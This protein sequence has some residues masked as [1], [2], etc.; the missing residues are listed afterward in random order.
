M[1]FGTKSD[2][3]GGCVDFDAVC[4]EVIVPAVTA[5]G[6]EP[7]RADEEMSGGI[8]HKP[9]FER[10]ILCDYAVADLTTANANVFCELG[11]RHALR[12]FATVL[13]FAEGG[14]LAFDVGAAAS[15]PV[16]PRSFGTARGRRFGATGLDGAA[17]R[18][19][20]TLDRQS[21][22]PARRGAADAGDR[23]REDRR[24]P[25]PRPLLGGGQEAPPA[26][27]KEDAAAVRAVED[28][29]GLL[30]DVEA[31][32][33]V[34]LLLSY[35]AVGSWSDMVRL[36]EEMTAPLAAKSDPPRP[37]RVRVHLRGPERTAFKP[38][39]KP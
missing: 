31:G 25:R 5:A 4:V 21:G 8:I 30:E 16:P 39:Q 29:L 22:V 20:R 35:R 11:V 13:V 24:L 34:D 6:L 26:V 15:R 14:R 37:P 10:L 33:V 18:G 27:R 23:P 19:S 17:G 12:P 1:P 9:M 28:G 7:L 3:A 36:V 2:G 32:V 38:F